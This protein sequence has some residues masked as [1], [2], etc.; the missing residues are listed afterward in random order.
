MAA[1]LAWTRSETAERLRMSTQTVIRMVKAG[2]LTEVRHGR[3]VR[4]TVRSVE[5]LLGH[6]LTAATA[7]AKQKARA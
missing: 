6:K 3:C 2:E 4:I 1:E 7:H 5:E